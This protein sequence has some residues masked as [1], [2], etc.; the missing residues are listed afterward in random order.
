[1]SALA[2]LWPLLV[3]L[4]RMAVAIGGGWLVLRS[5]QSLPLMFAAIGVALAI[6]G[7]GITLSVKLGAWFRP[8]SRR[9]S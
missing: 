7:G 9:A 1:L 6:Y 8:V 3:G 4:A 5:T 2:L